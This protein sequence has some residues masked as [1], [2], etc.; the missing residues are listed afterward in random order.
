MGPDSVQGAK[1][2]FQGLKNS[3]FYAISDKNRYA[4]KCQWSCKALENQLIA[5]PR[6]QNTRHLTLHWMHIQKLWLFSARKA[7][8]RPNLTK[9]RVFF[10][11]SCAGF[12]K[13]GDQFW[14]FLGV[15]NGFES[16]WIWHHPLQKIAIKSAT[17]HQ[18][19]IQHTNMGRG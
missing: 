7:S 10:F 17:T 1:N 12:M 9:N 6:I 14:F 8:E 19:K 16:T 5:K 15:E 3:L 11:Y 2:S 13:S 18:P 4:F